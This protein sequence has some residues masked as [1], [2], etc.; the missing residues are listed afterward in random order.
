MTNPRQALSKLQKQMR[1]VWERY[2][3]CEEIGEYHEAEV[4]MEKFTDLEAFEAEL[5]AEIRGTGVL[6]KQR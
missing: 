4:H 6:E 5:L 3:L 1:R 2:E